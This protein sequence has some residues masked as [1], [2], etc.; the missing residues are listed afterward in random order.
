M[1]QRT[2]Q[3]DLA[4]CI[5]TGFLT[6]SGPN[7][8]LF[9]LYDGLMDDVH[10]RR[11]TL[12]FI[13]PWNNDVE[14][15]ANLLAYYAPKYTIAIGHSYGWGNAIV[16]LAKHLQKRGRVID[17]GFAIDPVKRWTVL[18]PMAL[19]RRGKVRSEGIL[20]ITSWRQENNRPAGHVPTSKHPRTVLDDPIV[21]PMERH[22]TIDDN[23]EIHAA[24]I[25][26]VRE[27]KGMVSGG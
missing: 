24:I 4:V 9:G 18:K 15:D 22:E 1:I 12:L 13:R 26:E 14:T 19:A 2:R 25:N 16:K 7:A 23:A 5:Y 3:C 21:M 6:K 11:N 8:G 27:A 17:R 10:D 20:H